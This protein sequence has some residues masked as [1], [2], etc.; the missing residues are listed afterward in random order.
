MGT[1]N[2]AALAPGCTRKK[3]KKQHANAIDPRVQ[4][5]NACFSC[6]GYV[7]PGLNSGQSGKLKNYTSQQTRQ[8]TGLHL[9]RLIELA[10]MMSRQLN[11]CT[12]K[13]RK[14]NGISAFED[15][16]D[17]ETQDHRGPTIKQQQR[18]TPS[19]V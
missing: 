13:K 5:G 14:S 15:D 16:C 18:R 19:P 17:N 4:P 1:P 8:E 12:R 9:T 11:H 6:H 3:K 10:S 7:D 2:S